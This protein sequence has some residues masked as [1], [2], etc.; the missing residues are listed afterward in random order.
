[1]VAR[2]PHD[3]QLEF[4]T[5]RCGERRKQVAG[6]VHAW[7]KNEKGLQGRS[8]EKCQDPLHDSDCR[9]ERFFGD[10]D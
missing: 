5:K 7:Q 3:P 1:M 2:V 9:H 10:V 8:V 6:A 4:V